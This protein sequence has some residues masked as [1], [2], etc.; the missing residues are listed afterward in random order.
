MRPEV[1]FKLFSPITGLPGIG[2]R[3]A[4]LVE[5]LAGA[6]LIDLLWLLPRE[7]IDRRYSPSITEAETGKVATLTV[8]VDGHVAPPNK[9]QP[10]RV[11]CFDGTGFIT[12][13]FFHARPDYLQ[14]MLPV[15]ETRVISGVVE[16]YRDEIQMT[17]PDHIV[18][19]AEAASIRRVEPVYPMTASLSPKTL[20]RAIAAAMEDLPVLP[21]WLDP[22]YLE[23]Q[24]WPDWRTALLSAHAPED[25]AA[26]SL[27]TPARARLAYDE[28]LANQLTLAVMRARQKRG[29]GRKL[30]GDGALRRSVLKSLPFALTD[31]QKLAL[32]EIRDDMAADGAMLRLLQGDVG[33]GKTVVA[34]FTLLNA[35]ECGGQA[36]IMA[37]TEI[38]A[39]QHSA[40]ITALLEGSGVRTAILTGR[41]KGKGR[42]ELLARLANG[43]ID[44]LVGTHAIFQAGV[45]FQDLM[46]AVID[47]QHRFGVHQRLSL[48]EKGRGVDVLVMTATPI[49]R[50]LTL[51]VYGDL[52]V[53]R[54]TEKP[55]GRLPVDTRTISLERLP[56]VIDGVARA[57]SQGAKAYW[58]CPLVEE[59][60]V[61][62]MAAAEARHRELSARFGDA[63][64]LVHG[65]MK[66]AEKDAAI[67]R[68][69]TGSARILVATTVIEVGV[70]VPDATIIVIE[71][72]ERFGDR[73]GVV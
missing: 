39:R 12:L 49:P 59:S 57:L 18:P 30:K 14:K 69:A 35:I 72:A 62:D 10:Y 33:S 23:Q 55:A 5:K 61:S 31:T 60:E 54:L 53:S 48:T 6:K 37:P 13:V 15:G 9:R 25:A 42:Q 4:K 64:A 41:D 46:V 20:S 43:E 56:D 7:L 27:L 3:N 73:K 40:T 26:L 52:D 51:T 8:S 63:V 70:D 11:R 68:F 66:S 50:T 34:L 71:H 38:L 65:R 24:R 32:K 67:E 21:E 36:A 22:A 29:N 58:V 19:P 2:P 17:H 45:E 47:E 1:L 28:L 16:R 44:I